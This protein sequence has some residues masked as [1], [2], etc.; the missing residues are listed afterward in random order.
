VLW[1][2]SFQTRTD[3]HGRFDLQ[4]V[5]P[6]DYSL[7]LYH[8]RLLELGVSTISHPVTVPSQGGLTVVLGTP[9]RLTIAD[10]LCAGEGPHSDAGIAAGF[11]R[12]AETDV[13]LAGARVVFTWPDAHRVEE[14]RADSEGWYYLCSLPVEVAIGATATFLNRSGHRGEI[15]IPRGGILELDLSLGESGPADVVGT[16]RDV[17]GGQPVSGAEVELLGLPFSGVSDAEGV[18]RFEGVPPGAYTLE[19][20]HLAYGMRRDTL[21]VRGGVDLRL[22]IPLAT[23]P[24]PLEPITVTVLA[25]RNQVRAAM[26][27]QLIS[28]EAIEKAQARARDVGDLLRAQNL[29]GLVVTRSPVGVCIG[30]APGQVRMFRDGSCESVM[31]FVD[32]VRAVNPRVAADLPA[33]VVDEMVLFRPVEAGSLFGLGGGNGVLM[34]YTKRG[35]R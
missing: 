34:I 2:T 14:T 7:V 16:L 10:A 5:P 4:K 25:E 17:N 1:E 33:S 12:D 32:G 15:H 24:I 31:V 9:S 28:R 23:Q 3:R 13:P 22:D 11:V 6:G 35:R 18:F 20:R 8:P 21:Q 26:G 29:A 27:G 19:V 30:F